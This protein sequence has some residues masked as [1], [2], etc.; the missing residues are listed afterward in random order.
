MRKGWVFGF[1]NGRGIDSLT[2][3]GIG[4][5]EYIIKTSKAYIYA[6]IPRAV[7]RLTKRPGDLALEGSHNT[8]IILGQDRGWTRKEA[9]T[10]NRNDPSAQEYSNA[11]YNDEDFLTLEKQEMGTID[12]VAGRG[13]YYFPFFGKAGDKLLTRKIYLIFLAFTN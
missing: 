11:E 8:T 7:P 1:P 3:A 5:F 10:P 13:R 6:F 2:L 12:I 9:K 4:D